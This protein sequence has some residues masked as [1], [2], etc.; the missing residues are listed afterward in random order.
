M[1][2]T[3]RIMLTGL[4]R[5]AGLK[6][7]IMPEITVNHPIL[8]ARIPPKISIAGRSEDRI[9]VTSETPKLLG[10]SIF[11]FLDRENVNY[12][13]AYIPP[14]NK[15]SYFKT[16]IDR[17]LLGM[18]DRNLEKPP[19]T[20][21]K[22]NTNLHCFSLNLSNSILLQFLIR[23]EEMPGGLIFISKAWANF[24]GDPSPLDKLE[25][26]LREFNFKII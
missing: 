4:S 12:A 1:L 9:Y 23:P 22:M 10:N 21:K 8:I 24:Q 17:F 19:S 15:A 20:D 14:G 18:E 16:V 25:K 13:P 6:K 2:R 7:M 5:Y 3:D 26:D 11:Q